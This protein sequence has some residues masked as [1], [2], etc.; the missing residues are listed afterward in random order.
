LYKDVTVEEAI[1]E[2]YVG[3]YE[4]SPGFVFT[5]IKK[6]EQLI[7][8]IPGEGEVPLLPRSQIDFF[9]KGS[10][11]EFTFNTNEAGEIESMTM[12]P[13]GGDDVICKRVEE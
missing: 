5:V 9:I 12:H 11:Y 13:D 7:L 3:K 4:L 6:E 2:T 1:L 10:M 8:Q